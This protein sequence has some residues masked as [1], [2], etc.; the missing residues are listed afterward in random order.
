MWSR[1]YEGNVTDHN[2][3]IADF[4]RKYRSHLIVWGQ[5]GLKQEK[6]QP[7]WFGK[8]SDPYKTHLEVWMAG[9]QLISSCCPEARMWNL[10]IC[11]TRWSVE[12]PGLRA[13]FAVALRFL[14]RTLTMLTSHWH[15]GHYLLPSISTE[16]VQHADFKHWIHGYKLGRLNPCTPECRTKAP[17]MRGG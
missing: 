7:R 5:Q 12:P 14:L 13:Y 16:G 11:S 10:S 1:I 15:I 4:F 17:K 6:S 8:T 9:S 3:K 2:Q